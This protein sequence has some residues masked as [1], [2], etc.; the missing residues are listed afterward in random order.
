MQYIRAWA[1]RGTCHPPTLPPTCLSRAAETEALDLPELTEEPFHLILVEAV[2]DVTDV[3]H[4]RR[5]PLPSRRFG[6]SGLG[7]PCALLQLLLHVIGERDKLFDRVVI[8][9]VRGAHLMRTSGTGSEAC[10]TPACQVLQL[11]SFASRFSRAVALLSALDISEQRR[12][13]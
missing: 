3:H 6:A 1:V 12:T 10:P 13:C 7:L 2:R 9:V 11:T 5:R 8:G 4:S